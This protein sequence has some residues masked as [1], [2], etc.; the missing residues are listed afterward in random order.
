MFQI[1][2]AL[3]ELVL[4]KW[5]FTVHLNIF[6]LAVPLFCMRS[7]LLRLCDQ[8]LIRIF[9]FHRVCYMFY[10]FSGM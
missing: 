3:N 5:V 8:N 1:I 6:L 7:P 2:W 4:N 10:L 9:Y